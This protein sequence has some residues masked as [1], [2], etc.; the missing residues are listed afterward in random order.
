MPVTKYLVSAFH[1]AFM[2]IPDSESFARSHELNLASHCPV[3]L[4]RFL[5]GVI[6]RVFHE[7]LVVNADLFHM[8]SS[9]SIVV[10]HDSQSCKK[11][12]LRRKCMVLRHLHREGAHQ[13]GSKVDELTIVPNLQLDHRISRE[14]A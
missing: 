2:D 3:F 13:L 7:S 5:E 4:Q 12:L 9:D 8:S 10:L 11:M 6:C 14:V 1:L